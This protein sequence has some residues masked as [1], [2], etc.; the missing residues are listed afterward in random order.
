MFIGEPSSPVSNVTHCKYRVF[1][2]KNIDKGCFF[3]SQV[4][5]YNRWLKLNKDGKA[6]RPSFIIYEKK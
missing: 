6:S 4:Y 3:S 1:L 5:N 2:K